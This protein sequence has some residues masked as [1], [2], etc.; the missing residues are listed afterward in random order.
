VRLLEIIIIIN[1]IV[2][3]SV[4]IVIADDTT[5]Q[6]RVQKNVKVKVNGQV[7]SG[8]NYAL[9]QDMWGSGSIVPHILFLITRWR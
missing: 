1:V 6:C 7:V 5:Y 9:C 8:F 3:L 2:I 4:A